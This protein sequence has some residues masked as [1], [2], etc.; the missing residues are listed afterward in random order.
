MEYFVILLCVLALGIFFETK[1]HLHLYHSRKERIM[2][3]LNI[4]VYGMVWDYYATYRQH[5]IFPGEGLIGVRI[6]GLPLEEFLFFLIVPYSALV[7]YKWYD[8]YVK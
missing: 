5:W 8:K 2:Y 6:W 4:F 7:M 3:T 1:Y